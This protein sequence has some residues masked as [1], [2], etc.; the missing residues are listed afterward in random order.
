MVL[1]AGKIKEFDTPHNLLHDKKSTFY[2]MAHD[3][4]LT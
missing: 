4:G 1:D 3:A 2:S